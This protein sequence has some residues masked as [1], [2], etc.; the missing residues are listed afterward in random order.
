MTSKTRTL[1]GL[2]LFTLLLLLAAWMGMYAT[3]KSRRIDFDATLEPNIATA[4]VSGT[5]AVK[6]VIGVDSLQTGAAVKYR[7]V[8]GF[9]KPQNADSLKANFITVRSN[10]STG[11]VA[12]TTIDNRDSSTNWDWDRNAWIVTVSVTAGRLLRGEEIVLTYGANPPHGRMFAPPSAFVDTMR[13]AYDLTGAGSFQELLAPPAI[14]VSAGLPQQLVAYLPSQAVAGLETRLRVRVL[15]ANHNLASTV[16]GNL[17]LSTSDT[18][19]NLASAATMVSGDNGSLEFPVTF[20]NPG[21]HRVQVRLQLADTGVW[22]EATSNPVTVS[23][24]PLPLQTF[25]GDLHSHSRISHD[26]HGTG[27][28]EKA[29]E[30]AALD[31]YALTDHTS[32]DFS[33]QGGINETEWR[34]I[35]NDV[36]TYHEP[37]T[38]VTFL[39]YEYSRLA[40][41]GHHNIYF[42][43]PDDVLASLPLYRDQL[44]GEIQDMWRMLAN[45]LPAG[46][47]F[48]TAP[49][50]SGIMW[51]PASNS[52][53]SFGPGFGHRLYRPLIEIYSI[54]G[55]SEMYAPQHPLA[56]EKLDIKGDRYS[57]SGPHYAQDAWAAGEILGAIASSDDHSATPGLPFRGL[58]AVFATELTRDAVFAALQQRRVYATTGQRML[59]SFTIADH[60]MGERFEFPVGEFPRIVAEVHGTDEIEF[61][62][63]LKWDLVHGRRQNG[64]PVFE[65]IRHLPASDLHVQLAMA[66]SSYAGDAVYYLRVK[67]KNDVYDF[68]RRL[69]RQVWAW[70]SPIW[71]MAPNPLDTTEQHRLPRA[72]Q[73]DESYPNPS[74][75]EMQIG[76]YLP[77]S[78]RTVLKLY[79]M[80]GR[81]VATFFDRFEFEGRHS[82]HLKTPELAN[83]VYFLRL[84]SGQ[85][86]LQK[87]FLLIK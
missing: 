71:V 48:L 83:G 34:Q 29:R 6:L 24:A 76:F 26:G 73:L 85:Q 11:K 44:K 40:P 5:W 22:L 70:S 58:T 60:M 39:G 80:L 31:F 51:S 9:D 20:G 72:L 17:F 49:H 61:M 77:A 41:S 21:V 32:N 78:G 2:R 42:N 28:F 86:I 27:A 8:K 75:G 68:A 67:Q 53:V 57:S 74:R 14:I 7:F 87:K 46:V 69:H 37:G 15:D 35:K 59:L 12:I 38:F 64:H 56:Y 3:G 33:P 30:V 62:E 19:A 63:I 55:Q 25:W 36:I 54:H 4:R 16:T 18:M 82:I 23:V 81:E 1:W 50:H 52:G 47:E 13:I 43:A 65:V 10:S 84:Q 45:T 79:D 66:D